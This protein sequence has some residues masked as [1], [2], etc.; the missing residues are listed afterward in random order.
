MDGQHASRARRKRQ[1]PPDL[2]TTRRTAGGRGTAVAE[3][4]VRL[5]R[6]LSG[7]E[8]RGRVRPPQVRKHGKHAAV[9]VRGA[10]ERHEPVAHSP[11][12]FWG[13]G[14]VAQAAAR[15]K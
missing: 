11:S 5:A 2:K 4:S 12:S 6:R 14:A 9:V 8:G 1:A 13:G 7:W 10:G 15:P 3:Q